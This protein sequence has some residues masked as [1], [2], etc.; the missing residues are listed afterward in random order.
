LSTEN[1]AAKIDVDNIRTDLAGLHADLINVKAELQGDTERLEK[2]LD[3]F[4]K[5]VKVPNE[6]HTLKVLFA[7]TG[8]GLT[9]IGVAM[10]IIYYAR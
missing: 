4:V 6:S 9:I 5:Q 10:A 1:L 8:I 3:S 7:I 2:K